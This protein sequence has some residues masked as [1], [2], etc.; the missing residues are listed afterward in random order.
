MLTIQ[1]RVARAKQLEATGKTI[2]FAAFDDRRIE[3]WNCRG[4]LTEIDFSEPQLRTVPFARR[5]IFALEP[6]GTHLAWGAV[7][8]NPFN[9]CEQCGLYHP[10]QSHQQYAQRTISNNGL[11]G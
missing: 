2:A 11:V 1:E 4:E 10:S 8:Y 3:V 7:T 6:H 9:T 5:A